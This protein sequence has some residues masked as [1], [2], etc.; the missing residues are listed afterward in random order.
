MV[1]GTELSE[2]SLTYLMPELGRLE[3]LGILEQ[4]SLAL[5]SPYAATCLLN[6]SLTSHKVARGSKDDGWVGR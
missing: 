5:C 3:H 6:G 1:A 2:G 4:A